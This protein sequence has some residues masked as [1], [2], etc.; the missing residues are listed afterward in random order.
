LAGQAAA[1]PCTPEL[2]QKSESSVKMPIDKASDLSQDSLP[3][4]RMPDQG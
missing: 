2:S 3:H 1:R 4:T